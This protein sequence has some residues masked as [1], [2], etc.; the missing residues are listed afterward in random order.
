MKEETVLAVQAGNDGGL[1]HGGG[2]GDHQPGS[3]HLLKVE[4]VG[5]AD[6]PMGTIYQDGNNERNTFGEGGRICRLLDVL[7]LRCL[8][9]TEMERWE[10][11]WIYES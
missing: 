6:E 9:D 10:G 5:S 1:H 2:G 11:S 8:L 7:R 4:P 3:V